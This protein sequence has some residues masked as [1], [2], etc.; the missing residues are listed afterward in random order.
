MAIAL[1]LSPAAHA[2][3]WFEL[4]NSEAPGA[5]AYRLWGFIQPQYVYNLGGDV[6][7]IS[8]PASLAAYNGQTPAFNQ[9]G[10]DLKSRSQAQIFRARPGLRGVIPGTDEKINYFLLAELGNN[11]LTRERP[12]VF[13]DASISFNYIPG[14]RIRAG[15]GRLPIGEEAMLGEPAMDYINFTGVT[16]GLLNESFVAPYVNTTRLHSPVLG[17]PFQQAKVVGAA[18]AFRDVGI[19]IYDWFTHEQWEYAYALMA[20]QGNGVSFDS[21]PNSGNSD[22]TGRLQA[23]YI[24]G[25]KGPKREDVTVFAWH[26]SGGRAYSNFSYSR[27]RE[28][29]GAK[30]VQGNLRLGG[31]YIRGKGMIYVGKNPPF[32]DLGGNTSAG[33]AFEPVDLIAVESSNESNGYYLDMGWKL[34]P[35]WE[36]DLRYDLFDKLSNSAFDE[37]ISK[38]WTVGGQYFFSPALRFVVNYEFRTTTTPDVTT[39]GTSGTAAAQKTQLTDARIIGDSIG[40]RFSA[41]LT[42]QF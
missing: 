10:P 6:T 24:F 25:G 22:V 34:D 39:P 19:E 17:V 26:Q 11:A 12:A 13:T 5:P 37:R 2:T 7:G 40:N 4:Q 20:S 15:L 36:V 18:G 29:I 31:E 27:V 3:N 41:Q 38:T 16:G 42:Y 35:K 14:A 9:V 33:S 1:G 23:S 21:A 28:G 8:A 32:N 30:Y